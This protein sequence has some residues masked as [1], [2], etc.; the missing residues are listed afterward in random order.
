LTSE[1]VHYSGIEVRFCPTFV[2]RVRYLLYSH[3]DVMTF[4]VRHCVECPKCSTRY[5]VGFSPYPNGSYLIPFTTVGSEEWTLY[6]A[7]GTPPRSSRWKAE[8]MKPYQVSSRAHMLGFGPP[9]EIVRIRRR[10]QG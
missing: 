3:V 6:C 4:R 7:C 2:L 1:N 10:L 9:E 5:L 8:E